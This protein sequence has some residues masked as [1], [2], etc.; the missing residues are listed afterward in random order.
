MDI[1]VS[2]IHDRVYVPFHLPYVVA[3]QSKLMDL[4]IFQLLKEFQK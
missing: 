4:Y 3:C 2:Y 1:V